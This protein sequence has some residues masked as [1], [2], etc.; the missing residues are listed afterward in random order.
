L[1]ERGGD[2]PGD[3]DVLGRRRFRRHGQ[4]GAP[5]VAV[6]RAV[7]LPSWSF[8]GGAVAAVRGLHAHRSTGYQGISAAE[9]W[10][11]ATLRT[12]VGTDMGLPLPAFHPGLTRSAHTGCPE[13]HADHLRASYP[14]RTLAA[15]PGRRRRHTPARNSRN[16]ESLAVR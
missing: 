2:T 10:L 14:A 12:H 7:R 16:N 3:E 5:V 1:A 13:R 8:R 4:E 6:C 11:P 9:R 15:E